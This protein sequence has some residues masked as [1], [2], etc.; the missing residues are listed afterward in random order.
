MD[1]LLGR[2]TNQA[3][4]SEH[5]FCIIGISFVPLRQNRLPF[6]IISG[7]PF[8]TCFMQAGMFDMEATVMN[9]TD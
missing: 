4:Y 8:I 9:F 7:L 2:H 1:D 5:K 3:A 6:F